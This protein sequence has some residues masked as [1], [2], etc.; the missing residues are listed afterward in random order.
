MTMGNC[1]YVLYASRMHVVSVR[2]YF[3][4]NSSCLAYVEGKITTPRIKPPPVRNCL[5][6]VKT[7]T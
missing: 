4:V 7:K 5:P 6:K 1:L 3:I 2:Y